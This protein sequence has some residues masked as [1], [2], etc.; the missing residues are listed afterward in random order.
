MIHISVLIK[1]LNV[2]PKH[3]KIM[4]NRMDGSNYIKNKNAHF[5]RILFHIKMA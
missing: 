2:R 3:K 5:L 4:E 1:G